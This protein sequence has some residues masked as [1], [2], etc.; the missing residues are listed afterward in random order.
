VLEGGV[1]GTGF[2]EIVPDKPACGIALEADG[3][4]TL[5]GRRS[6]PIIASYQDGVDGQIAIPAREIILFPPAP[7]S[8]LRI[9]QACE[10]ADEDSLCWAVRLLDPKTVTLTEVTAGKYGPGHWIQWSPEERHIALSSRNEGA[11]WLHIVNAATGSVTTYPDL[12]E[13]A[14]WQIDRDSFAWTGDDAFAVN[15]KTCETCASLPRSFTLP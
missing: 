6:R 9:V 5:D 11:Q 13:N 1:C 2:V 3:S 12:S 8:G 14:N 15:V 4:L 7:Q 10:T